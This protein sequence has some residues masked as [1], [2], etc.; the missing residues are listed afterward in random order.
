MNRNEFI[1]KANEWMRTATG[2]TLGFGDNDLFIIEHEEAPGDFIFE[3]EDFVAGKYYYQVVPVVEPN[4][5]IVPPDLSLE[6]LR[7]PSRCLNFYIIGVGRKIYA[8]LTEYE[9][10]YYDPVN[11][12]IVTAEEYIKACEEN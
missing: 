8:S 6:E 1:A 4:G 2:G 12:E 9:L 10:E 7:N 5:K 11:Y 3:N